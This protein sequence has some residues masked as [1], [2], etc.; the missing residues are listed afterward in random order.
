M[1]ALKK[2]PE[3]INRLDQYYP[4]AGGAPPAPPLPDIAIIE[5]R[6]WWGYALAVILGATIGALL[7]FVLR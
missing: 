5:K 3:L 1:R 4:P 2:I 6:D 7:L